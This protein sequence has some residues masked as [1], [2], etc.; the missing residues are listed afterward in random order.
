MSLSGCAVVSAL[1]SRAMGGH[2]ADSSTNVEANVAAGDNKK[3]VFSSESN[4]SYANKG[5][6]INNGVDAK[7]VWKTIVASAVHGIDSLLTLIAILVY[8]G[9]SKYLS[10]RADIF[11]RRLKLKMAELKLKELKS[12]K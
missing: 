5:N 8:A 7:D 11:E 3:A 4:R 1:A 2:S 9:F 10:V 6:V 12:K